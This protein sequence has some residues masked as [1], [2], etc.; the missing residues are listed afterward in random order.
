MIKENKPLSQGGTL[1]L[2][3]IRKA[4]GVSQEEFARRIGASLV[5]V[6]RWERGETTPMLTIPQI[7]AFEAQLTKL[8]KRFSDLPDNIAREE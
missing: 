1:S 3:K 8:G 6:G 7:K 4:L 5:A 2:K